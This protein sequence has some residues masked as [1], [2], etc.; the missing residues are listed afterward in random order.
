MLKKIMITCKE[1][2]LLSSK[3]EETKLSIG[4]LVKLKMHLTMCKVC[5]NFDSQ[6]KLLMEAVKMI[7]S[8]VNLTEEEKTELKRMLNDNMNNN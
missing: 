6:V 8:D 4:D 3:S 1:A 2:T 5:A 7:D